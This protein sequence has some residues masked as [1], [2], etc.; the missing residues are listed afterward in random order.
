MARLTQRPV[1]LNL[2][3]IKL[4]LM[5]LVSIGHRITGVV[6]FLSIPLLLYL[7]GLSLSGPEGFA[8]TAAIVQS[9]GFK[10]LAFV[11]FWAL[12][13]HLLAGIRYLL[14]D[15]D[16]GIDLPEARTSAL[17]VFIGGAVLAVMGGFLL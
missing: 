14:L 1:F 15:L 13:H 4:P 3:K 6:L 16:V 10:L 9:I 8:Q 2:L 5:G 17:S 11:L 12:L 7:L